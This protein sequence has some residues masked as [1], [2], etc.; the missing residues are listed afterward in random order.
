[1]PNPGDRY[2]GYVTLGSQRGALWDHGRYRF[3]YRIT[4]LADAGATS[5]QRAPLQ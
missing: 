5:Q 1:M 2:T 4:R 3:A